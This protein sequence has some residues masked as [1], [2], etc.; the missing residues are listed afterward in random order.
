MNGGILTVKDISCVLEVSEKA[1]IVSFS[2][3]FF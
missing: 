1:A 2:R 3:V